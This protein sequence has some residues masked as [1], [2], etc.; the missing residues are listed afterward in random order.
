[1]DDVGNLRWDPVHHGNSFHG[2]VHQRHGIVCVVSQSLWLRHVRRCKH[3]NMYNRGEMPL[4]EV[5]HSLPNAVAMPIIA[6]LK[7]VS[8][9]ARDSLAGLR[10]RRNLPTALYR[11]S[12]GTCLDIDMSMFTG[13]YCLSFGASRLND[14]Q[15]S[16]E[17]V[18]KRQFNLVLGLDRRLY[19]KNVSSRD[20][21]ISLSYPRSQ[22]PIRQRRLSHAALPLEDKILITIGATLEFE[23]DVA[24]LGT[25]EFAAGMA[26]FA[27][28]VVGFSSTLI[29][30]VLT[31]DVV[32]LNSAKRTTHDHEGVESRACELPPSKKKKLLPGGT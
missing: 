12:S 13:C 23:L 27:D 11:G 29:S 20:V 16:G 24:D 25:S 4:T 9:D 15:V 22:T 31:C 5:K 28:S 18:C 32:P 14:V 6:S 19:V 3:R 21:S 8:A 17:R 7:P 2:A 26:L 10:N 30:P 1:M